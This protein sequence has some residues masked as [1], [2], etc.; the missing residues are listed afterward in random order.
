MA[1]LN[2][3]VVMHGVSGQ[4]GDLLTFIQRHGKTYVGKIRK[5]S[6]TLSPKQ[7][8]AREK[9]QAALRYAKGVMNNPERLAFYKERT[10]PGVTPFNL[11]LGDFISNPEITGFDTTLYTGAI[12]GIIRIVATDDTMVTEVR[13]RITSAAD[14]TVEEGIAVL[15]AETQTFDYAAT[16]AN[17]VLAESKIRAFAK[18]LPGNVSEQE[19]VL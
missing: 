5:K 16:V 11:A 15:N 1:K 3:N 7:Q 9:F 17:G 4:V 10:E 18:D 14:A 13:V 8:A 12:G 2:Y 6:D 19:M